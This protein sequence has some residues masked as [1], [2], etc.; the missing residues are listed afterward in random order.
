MKRSLA[1]HQYWG[2]TGGDGEKFSL[3]PSGHCCTAA[4][5]LD[6]TGDTAL[7]QRPPTLQLFAI[8]HADGWTDSSTAQHRG[9]TK[10]RSC[11]DVTGPHSWHLYNQAC[12]ISQC[13]GQ[14]RT[15]L[16]LQHS[17]ICCDWLHFFFLIAVLHIFFRS[18][19]K[20]E[21][22]TVTQHPKKCSKVR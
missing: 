20:P 10:A 7:I 17:Q 1:W 5:T 15:A 9:E 6:P 18:K 12:V 21:H 19:K 8:S 22:H 14:Q 3:L 16:G 4:G 13:R 11:M 2:F